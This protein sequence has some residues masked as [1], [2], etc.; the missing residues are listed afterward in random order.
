[1]HHVYQNCRRNFLCSLDSAKDDV[2]VEAEGVQKNGTFLKPVLDYR[3]FLCGWVKVSWD[4]ELGG[5]VE[6]E[7]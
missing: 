2:G 4:W 6:R 3:N 1:M 5:L 7:L